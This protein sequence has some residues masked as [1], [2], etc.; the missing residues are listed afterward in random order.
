MKMRAQITVEMNS[1]AFARWL[2]N[3]LAIV[4]KGLARVLSYRG[5]VT[6]G[7]RLAL[8]DTNG[9]TVGYAEI[10]EDDDEG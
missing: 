8:T 10:V 6:P 1:A 7:Y 2:A 9:N 3:E 5:M 4:L